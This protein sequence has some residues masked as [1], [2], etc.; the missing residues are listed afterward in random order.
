MATQITV[1]VGKGQATSQLPSLSLQSLKFVYYVAALYKYTTK[2]RKSLIYI[3]ET[4][5]L[6]LVAGSV[7]E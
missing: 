7:V 5:S 6:S 4:E 3:Q 2:S 1:L